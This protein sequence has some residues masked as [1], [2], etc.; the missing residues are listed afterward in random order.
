MSSLLPEKR[1]WQHMF[2]DDELEY[3]YTSSEDEPQVPTKITSKEIFGSDSE[4]EPTPTKI[5]SKQI[6]GSDSESD[7]DLD[8]WCKEK[9]M[10]PIAPAC[11]WRN[12]PARRRKKGSTRFTRPKGMV[13]NYNPVVGDNRLWVKQPGSVDDKEGKKL[14][15]EI[16]EEQVSMG[17]FKPQAPVKQGRQGSRKS[18][19][20][21][22]F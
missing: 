19:R 8:E 12:Q 9:G 5:T 2:D 13:R 7:S 1:T 17:I 16:Q 3:E 21:A 22:G 11:S 6:Y 4:D 14:F 18:A 20:L 10:K 15:K